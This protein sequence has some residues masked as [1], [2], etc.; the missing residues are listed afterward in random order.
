[1]KSIYRNILAVVIG[2]VLGSMV[3]MGIIMISA[4]II[5]PP[6]G[7][8]VTTAEGLKASLHLFQP[9]NY[10][11]PF[12]AHALGTFVGALIASIIA[13]NH[14]WSY[15]I[16]IGLIFMI[17]GIINVAT[18]PAPI[19]FSALDLIAAYVPMAYLGFKLGTKKD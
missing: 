13:A 15:A 17:G 19:W 6:P 7:A 2:L 10:I 8:D 5:P 18:L 1:M 9:K 14:K 11:M 3:N 12:L 4:Y 16:A